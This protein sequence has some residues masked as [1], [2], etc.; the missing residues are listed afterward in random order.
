MKRHIL[1]GLAV[2][3]LLLATAACGAPAAP[4]CARPE[5]ICVG[6]VT[7]TAG[8]ED[9]GLNQSAWEGI[10]QAKADGKIQRGDAIETVDSRD[11]AKNL[12][13]FATEHYDLVIAGGAG[14]KDE[15]LLAA[16]SYADVRFVGLNQEA[17]QEPLPNFTA[18]G[19]AEDQGGYL[20]GA[21]AGSVT[22]TGVVGAVCET[23]GL[24]SMWR[25]CEGFRLGALAANPD[26]RAVVAFHDAGFNEDL[27]TDED[28]A[29]KTTE[30][31][32][33]TG[34]DVI[35]GAGGRLG[36]AAVRAAGAKGIL[37]I[38]WE[39]DAFLEVPEAGG[40]VLT[41]VIPDARAVVEELVGSFNKEA[42]PEPV[43]AGPMELAPYHEG[44]RFIPASVQD[45]LVELAAGL[46]S[47]KVVTNVATERPE[48]Q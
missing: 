24:A 48:E 30:D 18:A 47:G 40:Y 8:L 10:Q 31:L 39:Q 43:L 23:A 42:K 29:R 19:F 41:S 38:G 44:G 46:R 17:P 45:M 13:A 34:A 5:V 37:S 36:E 4:D 1:R 35:L 15:T 12:A 28:W 27:F 16:R 6:L 3:P 11:Y 22:R 14:L 7:S 25:A 33:R 2:L 20:A 32:I 26:V 9:H 21:L